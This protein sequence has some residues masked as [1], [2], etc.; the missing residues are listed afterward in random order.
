MASC[1][2]C[3]STDTNS[4][5]HY[6][7]CGSKQVGCQYPNLPHSTTIARDEKTRK[8]HCIRCDH[9]H[10]N[11]D[12]FRNHAKECG[13]MSIAAQS[14]PAT[15]LESSPSVL[16]SESPSFA[17]SSPSILVSEHLAAPGSSPASL[18]LLTSSPHTPLQGHLIP[19]L[20]LSTPQTPSTQASEIQP[21]RYSKE[22]IPLTAG[23]TPITKRPLS[24]PPT[25]ERPVKR[26]VQEDFIELLAHP[27]ICIACYALGI[28][29]VAHDLGS[30]R[31][32]VATYVDPNWKAFRDL[33]HFRYGR[34][35]MGCG[36]SKDLTYQDEANIKTQILHHSAMGPGCNYADTIRPLAY[37]VW[38]NPE[39]KKLFLSSKYACDFDVNSIRK[40][41]PVW[42]T[43]LAQG[44]DKLT[45]LLRMALFINDVRGLPV[46]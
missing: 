36:I 43:F 30:C 41:F 2:Q 32:G 12:S 11:S 15:E 25:N 44:E 45:N 8:F 22:P 5:Y 3:G 29:G 35:C 17:Q 1:A 42:C 19:P 46:V 20:G 10:K 39:L 33:F 18:S 6:R 37:I 21:I 24:P 13:Q 23:H 38:N 16:V 40:P 7:V 34:D 26:T 27:E 9:K 14:V 28:D 4:A 31:G